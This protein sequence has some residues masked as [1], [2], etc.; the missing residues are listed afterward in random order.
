MLD[1]GDVAQVNRTTGDIGDDGVAELGD[2]FEFV[3]RTDE[4]PLVSLLEASAGQVDVF[5]ADSPRDFLDAD[6]ELRKLLL[7]HL[8]LYLV[9]EPA[10][11]L[12]G[13]SAFFGFQVGLD[14]IL[15]EA[16]QRF[17]AR[18]GTVRSVGRVPV[19][20][21][22]AHDRFGRRI[23]TQQQR[24]ACLQGQKQEIEFFADLDSGNVHVGS[25][26][27]LQGYIGLSRP[28][29]RADEPDIA[30]DTDGLFDR[31]GDEIL[32]LDRCCASQFGTNSDRRVRHVGQQVKIQPRQ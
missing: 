23:E 4:E 15:C 12:D 7:I 26:K 5:R 8:D 32:D 2:R 14:A 16:T 6:A 18:F 10:A 25:P 1:R 3:E 20:E 28:G 17:Q 13:G 22:E 21:P 11:D 9:F 27:E 29:D 19:Q 31:F 30:D 24:P